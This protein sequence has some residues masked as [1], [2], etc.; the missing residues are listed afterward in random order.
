MGI[1][2]N[3]LQLERIMRWLKD[4]DDSDLLSLN[5]AGAPT[6][7][8]SGTGAGTA[9]TGCIYHDTT[10]GNIYANTGTKASPVWQMATL[11]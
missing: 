7:G 11:S 10:D 3:G 2:P 9:G 6:S 1:R 8:T 4:M 5:G